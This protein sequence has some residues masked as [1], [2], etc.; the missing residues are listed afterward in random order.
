MES[1]DLNIAEYI[2]HALL[3]PSATPE[4]VEICCAQAE[5]YKFAAVCV[6][7]SAV[8][9]ARELLKGKKVKVCTVIG[10]PTGATTGKVKLYEA[11][12]AVENGADELDVMINLGWL[13]AGKSEELY[14]EIA[15]ICSDT[16]KVVK[17]ILETNV[18]TNTQKRLAAEIC[19][20]AGVGYLKTC[21]G[22]FGGATVEDVKLL[23]KITQGRVGIKASGGIRSLEAA[24]ELLKAGATR[25]G[26]SRGVELVTTQEQNESDL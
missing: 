7:P 25:L 19:L 21:T 14:Q 15:R 10:F 2:D 23:Q 1:F 24:R 11:Q 3:D 12:E 26:T 17:A 9:Q 6:Y 5:Q 4:Q 8:K 18:L 20:D 13:K 22:W 16:G